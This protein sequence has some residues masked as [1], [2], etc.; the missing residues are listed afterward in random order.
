MYVNFNYL[1]DIHGRT[2]IVLF[3]FLFCFARMSIKKATNDPSS[4]ESVIL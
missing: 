3:F 2:H 1:R 4:D